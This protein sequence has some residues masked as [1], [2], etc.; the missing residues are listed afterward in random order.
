MSQAADQQLIE[1]VRSGDEVAAG[2]ALAGGAD[3]NVTVDRHEPVL[4]MAARGGPLETVRLLVEAGAR[5]GPSPVRVA[6]LEA[7]ADVT[8]YLMANGGLAAEAKGRGSVLSE[9]LSYATFRPSPAELATLRV[10]LESGAVTAPGEERL[11]VAAVMRSVAPAVLR[12][13]L[14]YDADPDEQ[15]SDGTPAIVL[16]ARRGDHA[17]VDVLLE[18]GAEV[19]APDRHGRTALMHAV[20]RDERRVVAALLLAGAA[21]SAESPGHMTALELARGWQHQSVQFMLGEHSAGLDDVQIDRTTVRIVPIGVRLAGDPPMLRRLASVIDTAVDDLDDE[22]EAR[23][24]IE[25]ATARAVAAR[26]R[27]EIVPAAGAS[28]YQLDATAGEMHVVR[29]ALVELAY[30]AAKVMPADTPWA[31]VVDLLQELDRQLGH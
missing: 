26:L 12:L 21:V 5:V 2:Q 30:G 9:A 20:E 15:R 10:L 23:T 11:L 8:R 22:W 19:D 1:A 25:A 14:A 18:A 3:P 28:W 7:R 16:A 24:G 27:Q 17:A 13:V 29:S 31:D 4:T 6:V